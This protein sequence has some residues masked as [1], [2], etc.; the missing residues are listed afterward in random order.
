[1]KKPFGARV[2]L[3]G[4]GPIGIEVGKALIGRPNIELLGAADPAPDKAGRSI[5]E[6]LGAFRRGAVRRLDR[7]GALLPV[8][9]G[10]RKVRRRRPLH[11]LAPGQR[12]AADRAG[13]RGGLHVVST[14]EELSYP[15]L[16]H[17]ALGRRIDQTG[18]GAAASRCS[19]RAS[20]P[21]S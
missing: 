16:R 15:E 13:D 6:V 7:R 5:A 19:A 10:A 3:V 8:R 14:C 11:G 4:L 12:R 21:G 18:Q 1:M 2:A 9:T 17:S 20:T